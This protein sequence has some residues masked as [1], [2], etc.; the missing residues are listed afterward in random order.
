VSR[1]G[2]TGLT[3][4]RLSSINNRYNYYKRWNIAAML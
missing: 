4:S 3:F 1:K 2:S